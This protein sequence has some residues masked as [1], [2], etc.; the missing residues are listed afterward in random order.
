MIFFLLLISCSSTNQNMSNSNMPDIMELEASF[1]QKAN[2]LAIFTLNAKRLQIVKDEYVPSSE[3][4]LVEV[5][6]ENGSEVFSSSYMK[7]FFMVIG[8]V[9]PKN[10]ND[11]KTYEY[12]W[13]LKSNK[14]KN[15]DPGKYKA[16]LIIVAKPKSYFCNLDIE[17]K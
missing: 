5:Y 12:E 7:N 3:N 16:K 9:E 17:I 14:G 10:V 4:F 6:N 11:L 15:V 2:D 8:E 13:N 1:E